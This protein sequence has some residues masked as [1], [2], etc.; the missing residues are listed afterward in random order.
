MIIHSK[1]KIK[2]ERKR[3][4]KVRGKGFWR[5]I[6][7][8][9]M[10]INLFFFSSMIVG[11]FIG[12]RKAVKKKN[13][14]RSVEKSFNKFKRQFSGV[15]LRA[16]SLFFS[17]V[18][19]M[20]INIKLKDYKKILKKRN[21]AMRLDLLLSDSSDFIPATVN[22]EGQYIPVCL[23]LKG[24]NADHLKGDKWSFRIK[25]KKGY[26]FRG[27]RVFS[28]HHPEE[29]N[30]AYE[31]G[32]LYNI[33]SEGIVAPRY[34]FI[35]VIINGK[36]KGIYALEENFSKELIEFQG[37][38]EGIILKFNE[39]YY[40]RQL[41]NWGYDKFG[42]EKLKV[43]HYPEYFILQPR[44]WLNVDID[45]FSSTKI[46]KDEKLSLQRDVA[47]GLLESFRKGEKKASEVF[48]IEKLATFFAVNHLWGGEHGVSWNNM[49]FYFNP[50]TVKLEPIGFDSMSG[51][52]GDMGD[53]PWRLAMGEF[54]DQFPWGDWEWV[55][56][57][58]QDKILAEVYIKEALRITKPAY[59][60]NLQNKIKEELNEQLK[61]LWHE[62]PEMIDWI[63]IRK[64]QELFKKLLEPVEIVRAYTSGKTLYDQQ[65]KSQYLKV[66][67]ENLLTL[68]IEIL[69]FE[70]NNSFID[71]EDIK[72][73]LGLNSKV[74]KE[75]II[76]SARPLSFKEYIAYIPIDKR[77][78]VDSKLEPE[79]KIK[80][81]SKI[82]GSEN[83]YSQELIFVPKPRFI[84]SVPR[85]DEDIEKVLLKHEFLD[86]DKD[87]KLLFVKK[88]TWQ[89][90]NNLII[91]KGL[92][93]V[94]QSGTTLEFSKSSIL[95]TTSPINFG[96]RE[97]E[98]VI[99][100]AK[101]KTWGGLV[102]LGAGGESVL[103]YVVIQDLS[104][105]QKGGWVLT[106][107]VTF[108]DTSVVFDKVK[109]QNNYCEDAVNLVNS[110]FKI[111]NSLFRNTY[112]DALDCDF[113]NGEIVNT[114]FDKVGA[115]AIDVSGSQVKIKNVRAYNI[116][117]KG[118]SIGEKSNVSGENIKI[119][120]AN[121]GIV[122]KDFSQT[123]IN[124]VYIKEARFGLAAYQKKPEYGPAKI[125]ANNIQFIDVKKKVLCQEKSI[126][127]IDGEEYPGEKLD[128]EKLYNQAVK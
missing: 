113:S 126:V 70:L 99:L 121:F 29:R 111:L 112:S 59:L 39:N 50:I 104:G 74:L 27:M 73:K 46:G 128:V 82:L 87:K 15:V 72:L 100:K 71:K 36:D 21:E 18:P 118:L 13:I 43:P 25:T 115:D 26:T 78:I 53:L 77:F 45:A 28:I 79:C 94:I 4:K 23:R 116:G 122:S 5:K 66:E 86:Y 34:E 114:V 92:V 42:P 69:G 123:V 41:S 12:I 106:G 120:K 108:Y 89:V 110:R 63:K 83:I 24:D 93:L 55:S 75:I 119:E 98:P 80:I 16:K 117:D 48:D 85:Q 49:R 127:I 81:K 88:G 9:S 107:A 57:A 14:H 68:P 96:G 65:T 31:W 64:N 67:I 19:V 56:L 33:R 58:L 40:W 125:N 124:D 61:I 90:E 62:Y 20:E 47:M 60:N 17:S 10:V 84:K 1:Y 35:R 11:G 44:N 30:Y 3:L 102:V 76:D 22:Y 32:Y 7:I 54:S 52:W 8:V 37:N 101:D 95:L 105:I 97:G 103:R 91:P 38:R 2:K 6:L 109:I 51:A